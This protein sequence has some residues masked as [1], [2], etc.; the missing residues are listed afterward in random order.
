M[1]RNPIGAV[2]TSA[3]LLW[4]GASLEAFA[5]DGDREADHAALRALRD[6]V[7]TAIN[8]QDM[9][10]SLSASPRSLPLRP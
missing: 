10:A 6:R 8:K 2:L 4:A 7:A 1:I 3:I 5:A 9:K